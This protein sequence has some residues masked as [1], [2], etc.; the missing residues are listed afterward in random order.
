MRSMVGSV[1][2]QAA[3]QFVHWVR[4]QTVCLYVIELRMPR[5]RLP[6]DEQT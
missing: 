3:G 6:T 1:Q 4:R 5:I 2:L